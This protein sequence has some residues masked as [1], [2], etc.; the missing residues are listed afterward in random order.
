MPEKRQDFIGKAN[1]AR[2]TDM[3]SNSDLLS[4][5]SVNRFPAKKIVLDIGRC[6]EPTLFQTT[7]SL[8]RS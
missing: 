7:A 3:F 6:G 1:Y 5:L 8:A 2:L 4:D